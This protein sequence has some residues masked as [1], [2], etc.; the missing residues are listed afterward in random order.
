MQFTCSVT[1]EYRVDLPDTVRGTVE[2]TQAATAAARAIR[3]ARRK[4]PYK[5]PSSIVTV[6]EDVK[7]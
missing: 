3:A 5:H 2:A 4:L 1:F 6:L 7:K